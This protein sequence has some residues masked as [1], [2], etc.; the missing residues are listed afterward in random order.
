MVLPGKVKREELQVE[1]VKAELK[2]RGY[3]ILG[4]LFKVTDWQKRNIAHVA[5]SLARK[6]MEAEKMGM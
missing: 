2:S 4:V 6:W 5:R 1:A 3:G